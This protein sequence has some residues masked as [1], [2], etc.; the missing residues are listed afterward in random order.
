MLT[1]RLA[2][3]HVTDEGLVLKFARDPDAIVAHAPASARGSYVWIEGGDVKMF[4]SLAVNARTLIHDDSR[5]VMRFDL[6]DYRRDVARGRV[7]MRPDG[8][9]DVSLGAGG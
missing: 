2:S 6:Y 8:T 3:A 1:G 5:N 9:L 4:D 7:R